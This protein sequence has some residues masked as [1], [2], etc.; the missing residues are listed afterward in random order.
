MRLLVSQ[1]LSGNGPKEKDSEINAANAEIFTGSTD[2]EFEQMIPI[3]KNVFRSGKQA[4][5]ADELAAFAQSK[6]EEIER[7]CGYNYQVGIGRV[8]GASEPSLTA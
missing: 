4:A 1:L 8:L 6:Q 5:F 2:A 3:I 7:M